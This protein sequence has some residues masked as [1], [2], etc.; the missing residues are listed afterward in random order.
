MS[1]SRSERRTAKKVMVVVLVVVAIACLA[2][3]VV[4]VNAGR[5]TMVVAGGIGIVLCGLIA[6]MMARRRSEV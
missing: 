3:A 2:V 1:L 6:G 4:G 5:S